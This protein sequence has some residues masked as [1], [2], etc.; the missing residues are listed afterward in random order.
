[1]LHTLYLVQNKYKG[2]TCLTT[3]QI[4]TENGNQTVCFKRFCFYKDKYF[5]YHYF[6]N[7][8]YLAKVRPILILYTK[9][10]LFFGGAFIQN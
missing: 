1:M 5:A 3:M 10:F 7:H 2:I 8:G 6:N 4:Q 9:H